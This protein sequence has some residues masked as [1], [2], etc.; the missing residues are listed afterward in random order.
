MVA[1]DGVERF[2]HPWNQQVAD[3]T[4][5]TK[6]TEGSKDGYCVRSVCGFAVRQAF[7]DLPPH[8]TNRNLLLSYSRCARRYIY[9]RAE[10][11][12]R[13]STLKTSFFGTPES[14]SLLIA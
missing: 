1:R 2:S 13:K 12:C 3:S 4:K 14:W 8:T 10:G 6:D 5:D 9:G 11:A 7:A